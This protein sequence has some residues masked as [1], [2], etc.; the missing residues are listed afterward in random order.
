MEQALPAPMPL[1]RRQGGMATA[2]T[3]GPVGKG[4][5]PGERQ[6]AQRAAR[7]A[8]GLGTADRAE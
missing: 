5:A 8:F 4:I 7:D 1:Q 6:R 2:R 3:G